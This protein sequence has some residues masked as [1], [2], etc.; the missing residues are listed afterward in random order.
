M[1][2]QTL[3][4]DDFIILIWKVPNESHGQVHSATTFSVTL[5]YWDQTELLPAVCNAISS[6]GSWS[7]PRNTH[8]Q[9]CQS[10]LHLCGKTGSAFLQSGVQNSASVCSIRSCPKLAFGLTVR[11]EAAYS[12]EKHHS[13]TFESL[14]TIQ[15]NRASVL[16]QQRL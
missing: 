15:L 4:P 12:T 5:V 2:M 9:S 3:Y 14:N 13:S 11:S 6:C 10:L 8:L 16:Q 1:H 7:V